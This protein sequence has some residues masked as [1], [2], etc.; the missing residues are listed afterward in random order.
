MQVFLAGAQRDEAGALRT[1]GGRVLCV[2]ASGA[3]L[4]EAREAAYERVRG[5]S[6]EGAHFR[7]DIGARESETSGGA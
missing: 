6:F 1:A 2:V 4:A 3:S 7:T 5:I